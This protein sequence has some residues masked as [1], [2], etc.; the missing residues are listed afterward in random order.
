MTKF[1]SSELPRGLSQYRILDLPTRKGVNPSV[2]KIVAYWMDMVKQ[3]YTPQQAD[4]RI[5]EDCFVLCDETAEI[6]YG[7]GPW[8]EIDYVPGSRPMLEWVLREKIKLNP[9]W[10]DLRKALAIMRYSRDICGQRRVGDIELFYG[11]SEEDVIKKVATF[12]NEQTRVMIRLA[13]IAGLPARYVGHISGDH[14]TSEIKIDGQWAFFDIRGMYYYKS[15]RQVASIW[16][17]RR[18]PSLIERQPASADKDILSRTLGRTMTRTQTFHKAITCIAPYR[19]GD[20]DWSSHLWTA[21]T[22]ELTTKLKPL[23]EKWKLMLAEF[24]GGKDFSKPA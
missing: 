3:V 17:L 15:G 18:D 7:T 8:D 16:D 23:R 2:R 24:H 4:W 20:Y 13:Q 10:T 1:S 11:G 6:L 21:R 5:A 9:K 19:C 14:G 22:D 12:C